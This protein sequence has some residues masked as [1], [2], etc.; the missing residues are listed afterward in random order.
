M[1]ALKDRGH[2]ARGKGGSTEE[3]SGRQAGARTTAG[4]DCTVDG[5]HQGA[6]LG[7]AR[8]VSHV[9]MKRIFC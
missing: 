3:G 8:P 7:K 9:G 5:E 4:A 2:L 6:W 1:L